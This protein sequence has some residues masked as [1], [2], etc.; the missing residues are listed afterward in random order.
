MTDRFNALTVALEKDIRIDD[1]EGIMNAIRQLR[2]VISVSGNV[3]DAT[4]WAAEE[5]SRTL[6]I[7]RAK[8]EL[9]ESIW[10]IIHPKGTG[11][12]PRG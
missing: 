4:S 3:A 10:H 5:P 1:A 11:P 12:A 7:N 9:V 2:G 6:H 8:R